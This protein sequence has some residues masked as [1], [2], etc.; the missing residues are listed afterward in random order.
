MQ[1]LLTSSP[2]LEVRRLV[3]LALPII[4][5][6]L[7][8]TSMGFVDTLMVGRLGAGALAGIAL[9]STLYFF[10]FLVLSGAVLAV[11]PLVSQAYGGGDKAAVA[12]ALRQALWLAS[13]LGA[14]GFAFY[15]NAA[16]LLERLGQDPDTTAL[17][18]AYLRAIAWGIL[19]GLW[20]VALRG[21]LEGLSNPRPILVVTLF[22][23]GLNV[24]ANHS[25]MFGNFGF[26]A[27]GLV[28]TGVASAFVYWVMF[29]LV[30]LYVVFRHRDLDLHRWRLPEARALR[31]L[32]ALG[33]PISLT[34]AFESG[35][36]SFSTLLM[37]L[38]GASALAAHQIALQ[39]SAL[40]FMVPLG[41][42]I[43]TAVRVAQARGRGNEAGARLT[44]FVGMG[45]AL[46]FM[47]LTALTFALVP[48]RITGLYLDVGDPA[49]AA[50]AAG[51]VV[52]LRL[53]ALFQL[54]DGL[55]VAAL[56]ALR[57]LKDT[58]VP[59]IIA[60]FSYWPVG[61]GSGALLAFAFGMGGPGL[62]LGMVIGLVVASALLAGRFWKR[63]LN[64]ESP[65]LTARPRG[66]LPG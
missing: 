61:L 54:F 37:G 44:G 24:L 53:A 39:S 35:L 3:A 13:A 25:L 22:G 45:L 65:A 41:L 63:S 58:R 66:E 33:W 51:A 17:A 15:W 30:A 38:L 7:A 48:D 11:G 36:F 62:W 10:V 23:V 18:S 52:F 60:F 50:V 16:P 1:T 56:G 49:N 9:G 12:R 29:A 40:A 43:A 46:A 14:L 28:G 47:S 6:Q 2:A 59:M 26:P 57:G 19:P 4:A 27:L 55:Q 20:L 5:A 21:L 8:Q 32:I 34:L 64:E 31:E 42:S